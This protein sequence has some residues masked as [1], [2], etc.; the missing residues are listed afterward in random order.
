MKNFKRDRQQFFYLLCVGVLSFCAVFFA[1][2]SA[3]KIDGI[4]AV[5]NDEVITQSDLSKEMQA[6]S[7]RKENLSGKSLRNA[8]LDN[9][10]DDA[11]ILQAAKQFK[12]QPDDAALD[13]AIADIA[14]SNHMTVAQ[15]FAA[16]EQSGMSAAAY[17]SNLRKQMT[18]ARFLHQQFGQEVKISDQEISAVQRQ[19]GKAQTPKRMVYHVQNLLIPVPESASNLELDA[20][21]KRAEQLTKEAKQGKGLKELREEN[22]DTEQ[23]DLGWRVQEELPQLFA[24]YVPNMKIGEVVGPLKAPNGMQLIQL[25][26]KRDLSITDAPASGSISRD[27]AKHLVYQ[28]KLKEAAQSWLKEARK[29]AFIKLSS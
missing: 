28:K 5:V 16:A 25:L 14:G 12:L 10:I 26:E 19:G 27:Q 6:L 23:G 15:L 11:I 9:L 18:V 13:A 29:Q 21:K 7:N 2:S 1:K 17:K 8:A 22:S 3:A 4:V 24:Q 20:A